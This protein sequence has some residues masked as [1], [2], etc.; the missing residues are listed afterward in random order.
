MKI[1]PSTKHGET[2]LTW[3]SDANEVSE[4]F[5]KSF[6]EYLE[7]I[8]DSL[9]SKKLFYEDELGLVSVQ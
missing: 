7:S 8:R 4:D 5:K 2:V 3:D 1:D 6:G 9:L